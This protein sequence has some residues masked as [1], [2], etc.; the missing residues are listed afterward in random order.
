[1]ALSLPMTLRVT[2][3][4]FWQI[5]QANPDARLELNANGEIE[6]MSPTGWQSSRRNASITAR[7]DSWARETGMGAAFDSSGGF[8]LPNGAVRSPDAAWVSTEK[9]A[10]VS[11]DEADRFF[12]GCPDFVIELVSASDDANSLRAKMGEYQEN[13]AALGWL[14]IPQQRQVEIFRLGKPVEVLSNPDRLAAD[15]V[16]PGFELLAEVLWP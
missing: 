13:G 15:D 6:P 1:M 8:R 12:P 9:M 5:C 16:V 3:E 7:L 2:P 10:R 11:P 14:I 4:Q